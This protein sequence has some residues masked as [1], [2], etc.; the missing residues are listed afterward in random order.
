M[1]WEGRILHPSHHRYR[2]RGIVPFCLLPCQICQIPQVGWMQ[3]VPPWEL[4]FVVVGIVVL[5]LECKV[6]PGQIHQSYRHRSSH[7]LHLTRCFWFAFS[8]SKNATLG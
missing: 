6:H 5:G 7:H 4:P 1:V 8:W 2:R 3:P